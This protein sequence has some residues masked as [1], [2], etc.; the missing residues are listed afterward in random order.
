VALVIGQ[1]AAAEKLQWVR[2]ADDQRSF[3]L[4]PSGK[5]FIP[6][7]VNYDH[8]DGTGRL[9]EDYWIDEWATVEEDFRE[10][11]DLGANVVRV[12]LQFGKFMDAPDRP[13]QRSLEQL[14]KLVTLAEQTGLYLDLTGLGC[15]HKKDVPGWYDQLDETQRWQAQAAFWEAIA[16]RC[17]DSPAI[18]CY[19]LMN[20]PVVPG[21]GKRD[22]WLGPAFG[23]K[24]FV[25][26][27]TLS[28]AG[29]P[30]HEVAQQWVRH[31]VAAIRKH[32]RRHLI[33]VGLVPWSLNRPGLTSGFDPEKIAA[34]L[35]FIA[36]HIYPKSGKVDEA[37]ETLRGFAAP[38]KPVVIEEI[39]PLECN[40]AELSTFIDQSRAHAAG[41]IGF[42]WG[43]QPQEYLAEG[44]LRGALMLS[45]LTLFQEKA[46]AIKQSSPYG[47]VKCEGTY[48]HH[49]Q[50]ICI[51]HRD[52][53]YW[54]FTTAMVKTDTQGK[55]LKEIEVV[56]HHGDLCY[57]DGKLYVAVN[58]GKFNR[59]AG[60]ANNWVYVYDA[61]DLA[62]IS[63]HPVPEVVHGAGGMT[64]RDGR[65]YIV[66]GL[67][68]GIEE[69][70]VY[71]YDEKFNFI[72]KHTLASGYTLLGIQTADFDGTHFWFGCY[73]GK[74]LKS[75]AELKTVEKYDFNCS[76]G[77]ASLGDGRFL[78]ARG[79]KVDDRHLGSVLIAV[80]DEK[81]G[82]RLEARPA[83]EAA[84]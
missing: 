24:H 3:V 27:I 33:T 51:N 61:D 72:K 53:I 5:P 52:A 63:K 45:W 11:R 17:A 7:G 75:D 78:V 58:L 41:W 76:L 34:D 79:G 73:G 35:D 48:R 9:I 13:N 62:F 81:T 4:E 68:E 44:T 65:F 80:P 60:Q 43:R 69:N 46:A 12:H 84:Q 2:V 1:A 39:F 66:G 26:F 59:P 36:V 6:W 29:R 8:Q 30:R 67:P 83:K 16:A 70:Y 37:M 74:L 19:D 23:D 21:D 49:L 54:S 71:E 57:H 31:L 25:Q 18:F 22:D 38:G 82:L 40:A 32:D 42:Y 56:T 20:E 28:A 10:M 14:G 50:G 64:Y 47:P 55:V 77:I 15:Y